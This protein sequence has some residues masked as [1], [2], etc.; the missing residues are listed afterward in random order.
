MNYNILSYLIYIPCTIALTVWVANTLFKSGRIF[1]VEIF[2]GDEALA[3]SVNKLLVV[4]FYLINIGYAVY[5]LQIIG[6]IETA[7]VLIEKL[8]KKIGSII[9]ILGGM[10]FF[11]LFVFFKLRNKAKQD[12]KLQVQ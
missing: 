1:L 7:Q 9:L 10:H 11:N 4:G 8:S 3:D 5:T 6:E 2:H 12:L